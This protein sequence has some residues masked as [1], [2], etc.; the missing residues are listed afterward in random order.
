V[1]EIDQL[2]RLYLKPKDGQDLINSSQ[3]DAAS[4]TEED[5]A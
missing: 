2:S 3:E 5:N 1:E 4:E